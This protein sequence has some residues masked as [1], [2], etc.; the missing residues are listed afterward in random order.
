MRKYKPRKWIY[1]PNIHPSEEKWTYLIDLLESGNILKD[2]EVKKNI[3]E[4]ENVKI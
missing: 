2:H 1:N 4:K 3:Q